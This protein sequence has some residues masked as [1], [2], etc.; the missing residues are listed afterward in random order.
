MFLATHLL[1]TEV[2]CTSLTPSWVSF[3]FG[4]LDKTK[5]NSP[6]QIVQRSARGTHSIQLHRL[7]RRTGPPYLCRYQSTCA[8]KANTDPASSNCALFITVVSV[9]WDHT[10]SLKASVE[11]IRQSFQ[12]GSQIANLKPCIICVYP[13]GT[14]K[15][16]GTSQKPITH[17]ICPP[18]PKNIISE[19][20]LSLL[21]RQKGRRI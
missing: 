6:M 14:L 21:C 15:E 13:L 2:S 5:N 17:V 1:K 16:N 11:E 3:S 7:W 18:T 19:R 8:L 9:L 20:V 10:Q 12:Q 4:H